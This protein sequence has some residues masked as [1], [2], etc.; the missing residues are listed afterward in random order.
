MQNFTK[1][2]IGIDCMCEVTNP[3]LP[4]RV[5]LTGISRMLGIRL[6]RQSKY[7]NVSN[8][9]QIKCVRPFQ[10]G[11]GLVAFPPKTSPVPLVRN[12]SKTYRIRRPP[13][14]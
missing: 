12:R 8:E 3:V 6:T 10:R 1:L 2:I 9:I 5:A 11:C 7:Y 14:H 4:K 13:I